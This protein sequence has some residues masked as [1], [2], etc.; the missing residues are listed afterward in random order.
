LP[1]HEN[2]VKVLGM[3]ILRNAGATAEAIMVMELCEGGSCGGDIERRRGAGTPYRRNELWRLFADLVEA[4]R[5]LHSRQPAI[6]HR[7]VK[8]ENLLLANDG[9]WK[10]CDFGSATTRVYR[11]DDE[12]QRRDAEEDIERNTTMAYRAPEVCR[13]LVARFACNNA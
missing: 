12:Q 9:V 10:L 5:V 7:D 2:L 8:P 3:Q 13:R 6:A 1:R 4:V 11:C